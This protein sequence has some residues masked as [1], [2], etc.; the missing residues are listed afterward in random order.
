MMHRACE[1][2]DRELSALERNRRKADLVAW[3]RREAASRDGE[4]GWYVARTRWRAEQVAD[5]L[6]AYGIEAICPKARR[7]KR[8]PRSNKRYAVDIPLFGG[9]LFV[10]LLHAESAWVGLLSF[11]GIAHLQGSGER[12]IPLLEREAAQIIDMMSESQPAV[13]RAPG[14]VVVGDRVVHPIGMFAEL[15]A[16]VCEIDERKREAIVS[17]MLFGREVAT[18]CNI[19]DLERLA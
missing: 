6:T 13:A 5:E 2:T 15:A 12:P 1:L 19:D 3:L 11:D 14:A 9:Y 17:T 7:W 8:Y 10:R 4:M 18:R 16:T